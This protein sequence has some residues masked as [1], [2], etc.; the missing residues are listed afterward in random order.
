MGID[1]R[2]EQ[3]FGFEAE[4]YERHR[5]GWPAEAVTRA[6]GYLGLGADAEVVD[7]AAGTGK[8]TRELIPFVR[9]VI[10]V[11][12]SADMRRALAAAVPGAEPL[13]G[14]AEAMPLPDASVDGLFAAEAFHWFATPGAVAEIARVVRPGG[15]IALMWNMH[16]LGEDAWQAGTFAT[17]GEIGAPAPGQIGRHEL[18]RWGQAFDG[19]PFGSFEEFT[20]PHEQHTD[21]PGLVEHILT[22]S[23]LRVLDDARREE[24]RRE[25]LSVLEREHPRPD[26]VVI[27]YETRVYCARRV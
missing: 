8:L 13:D 17:L 20:A 2:A 6:L 16:Q 23:H 19:A 7:L 11:E 4:A 14:T 24:L 26:D 25:L 5:P 10:A 12:P 15:G 18:E 3:A 9:R 22:W 27:S 21:V 1:P